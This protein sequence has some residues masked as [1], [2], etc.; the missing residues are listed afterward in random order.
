MATSLRT[1]L[2]SLLVL[3]EGWRH[4]HISC[5]STTGK[6]HFDNPANFAHFLFTLVHCVVS[7]LRENLH[8]FSLQSKVFIEWTEHRVVFCRHLWARQT[9]MEGSTSANCRGSLLQLQG[10]PKPIRAVLYSTEIC[11]E[12]WINPPLPVFALQPCFKIS[13]LN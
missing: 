10:G 4:F 7:S 12:I 1:A 5:L 9:A 11:M 3:A 2:D 8:W 6:C 13:S